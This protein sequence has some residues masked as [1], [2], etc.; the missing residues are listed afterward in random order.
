MDYSITKENIS[1]F[2]NSSKQI[3]NLEIKEIV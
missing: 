1:V 2:K 3:L